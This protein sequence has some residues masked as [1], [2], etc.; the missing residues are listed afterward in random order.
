MKDIKELLNK[1]IQ[2]DCLEIM[3]EIP[4]KSID[5]VLTDPPYGM[6]KTCLDCKKEKDF[7]DFPIDNRRT[8]G[9]GSYC[10]RCSYKRAQKSRKNN[11]EHYR[12]YIRNYMRK[13]RGYSGPKTYQDYLEETKT[14]K[15]TPH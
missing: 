4:D 15:L 2:G 11:L 10:K 13:R 5:L 8:D 9:Q 7:I 6:M 14:S 3:R 1:V 12:I